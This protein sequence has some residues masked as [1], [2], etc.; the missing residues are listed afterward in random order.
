MLGD[1]DATLGGRQ[2]GGSGGLSQDG[3][4]GQPVP[5]SS[6]R[7]LHRLEELRA[8]KVIHPDLSS[9]L[10]CTATASASALVLL[11]LHMPLGLLD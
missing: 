6:L 5:Y 8:Q 1:Q 10:P 9:A 11:Y 7:I 2:A 3:P 4:L